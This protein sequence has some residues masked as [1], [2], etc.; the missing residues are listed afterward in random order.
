MNPQQQQIDAALA[1][2]AAGQLTT[3]YRM[4][5]EL[6]ATDHTNAELHSNLGGLALLLENLNAAEAHYRTAIELDSDL[7]EAQLGLARV[8]IKTQDWQRGL[9]ELNH[10]EHTD[11]PEW[12]YL[13]GLCHAGRGDRDA[14]RTDYQQAAAQHYRPAQKA[15][16]PMMLECGDVLAAVELGFAM[17][18]SAKARW[19][20]AVSCWTAAQQDIA[21]L[22]RIAALFLAD[23][24][25]AYAARTRALALRQHAALETGDWP[26]LRESE[27]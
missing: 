14:A 1:E 23:H 7:A 24:Q 17:T 19:L 15:L 21:I 27:W 4:F 9:E 12:F 20:H 5:S 11:H 10:S 25:F 6:A 16:L 22:D 13:H 18:G 2:A 26:A 8:R 3:A